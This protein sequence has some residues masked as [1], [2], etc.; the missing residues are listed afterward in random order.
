MLSHKRNILEY[1]TQ[2]RKNPDN[3]II[4]HFTDEDIEIQ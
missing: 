2:S 1:V 3:E 4:V